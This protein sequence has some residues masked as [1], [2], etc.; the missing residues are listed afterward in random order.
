MEFIPRFRAG[1]LRTCAGTG[2]AIGARGARGS[3]FDGIERLPARRGPAWNAWEGVGRGDSLIPR[4]VDATGRV[5][6]RTAAAPR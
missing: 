1:W 2:C 3:E 6:T 5:A 4:R